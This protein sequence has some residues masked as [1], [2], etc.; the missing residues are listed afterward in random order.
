MNHGVLTDLTQASRFQPLTRG[1]VILKF[2][3]NK[4]VEWGMIDEAPLDYQSFI[5]SI[6][7]PKY[8]I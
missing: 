6:L 3:L 1:I 5:K 8:D 7:Q 2:A 4:T